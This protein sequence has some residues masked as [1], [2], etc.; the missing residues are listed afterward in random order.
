MESQVIHVIFLGAGPTAL[1]G[2]RE[3][4]EY[5][6]KTYAIGVNKYE[7]G[8]FSKYVKQIGNA[9]PVKDAE[10]VLA[11]LGRFTEEHQGVHIL[12]PTGDEYV[13]FLSM[14]RQV[15]KKNFLFSLMEHD[16]SEYLLDKA[17]FAVLC[18]EHGVLAPRTWTAN[19]PQSLSDWADKALYP[20][21]IKPVC[22]HKWA[23]VYGL[24]KGF[25]VADRDELHQI[26]TQV[27]EYV[28]E[29]IVQEV[30]EGSDDNIVVLAT[31]FNSNSNPSQ[32]FTGRKIR[33]YPV[34]YGTTT[35]AVSEIIKAII[36]P[37]VKVL[38]AIGYRG[39]CD[40]EFKYDSRDDQYKIIEVNPRIGRWYR[41]ATLSGKRPLLASILDLAGVPNDTFQEERPQRDKLFW[42]FPSRDLPA[43][44]F[45]R[46]MK[47]MRA[48]SYYLKR[49]KVWCV[50]DA[51]DIKPF[52]AYFVEMVYKLWRYKST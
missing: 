10:K 20:C 34:G 22:Y 6:L 33:Q 45:N 30:I 18:Q 2:I 48:L 46:H 38:Q 27:S 26:Y 47:K 29:L 17:R 25:V 35:C 52:F 5:G 36:E 23:K 37:S 40:V 28:R 50:F 39:V 44:L 49:S 15:L 11:I 7:A 43:I 9:D 21:F 42:L 4:G 8:L 16:P 14:Y 19:S 24:T 41:L 31:Y 1:A 32:I 51:G 12:I 13:E 3:V